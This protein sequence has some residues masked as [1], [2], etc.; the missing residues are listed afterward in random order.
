MLVIRTSDG[1]FRWMDV[2]AYLER[3]THNWT[4]KITQIVFA[5]EKIAPPRCMCG[6]SGLCGIRR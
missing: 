6:A 5:G 2:T 4:K 3:E 1:Q